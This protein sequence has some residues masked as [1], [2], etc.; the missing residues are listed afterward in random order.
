MDKVET[1]VLDLVELPALG[2]MLEEKNGRLV[3]LDHADLAI[4]DEKYLQA[5]PE[6]L[7]LVEGIPHALI[8]AN[9]NDEPQVLIPLHRPVRPFIGSSPYSTELVLIRK[10]AARWDLP[11]K[12]L[13]LPV[14]VSLSFVHT[15]TLAS[16]LYLLLLRFLHRDYDE[17]HRLIAGVGTDA[18]FTAE[19][20]SIMDE[21]ATVSCD[22]GKS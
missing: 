2:M 18:P 1:D 11:T 5:R 17:L 22:P 9:S 12:Y 20:E 3:S 13:L 10:G 14:H 8:L 16:A 7:A 4:C 21:I 19:E 6:L 15:P